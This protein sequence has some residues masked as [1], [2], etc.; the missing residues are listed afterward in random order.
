MFSLTQPKCITFLNL[1]FSLV[2]FVR[3]S[4]NFHIIV[5]YKPPKKVKNAE[6][7]GKRIHIYVKL[8]IL[9]I[10]YD[11]ST[12]LFIHRERYSLDYKLD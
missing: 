11:V 8:Y 6:Q 12:T 7:R 1:A 5:Y 3:L 2:F 10:D 4:L 9:L